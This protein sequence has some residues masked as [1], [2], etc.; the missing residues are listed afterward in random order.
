MLRYN[1]LYSCSG[2]LDFVFIKTF[3]I[4]FYFCCCFCIVVRILLFV[5]F[6][7]CILCFLY[8]MYLFL[9]LHLVLILGK[10]KCT[11]KCMAL[12][13]TGRLKKVTINLTAATE[14]KIKKVLRKIKSKFSEQEYKRLYPTS[15]N[16]QVKKRKSSWRDSNATYYLQ[17]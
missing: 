2:K 10:T 14:W 4:F 12:L 5:F 9:L 1:L 15:Q 6:A 7:A 13:N 11:K 17:H 3:S 16:T 8:F